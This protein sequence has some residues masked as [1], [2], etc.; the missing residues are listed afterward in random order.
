MCRV[1]GTRGCRAVAS[2]VAL[3]AKPAE[4]RVVPHS[5]SR[6]L[7]LSQSFCVFKVSFKHICLVEGVCEVL[8]ACA[9]RPPRLVA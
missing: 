1:C 3:A 6:V 9:V 2:E 8:S 4:L 5:G 7:L